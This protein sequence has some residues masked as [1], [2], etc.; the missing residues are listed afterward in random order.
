MSASLNLKLMIT[1][2]IIAFKMTFHHI[3][4]YLWLVFIEENNINNISAKLNEALKNIS[5][6][7]FNILQRAFIEKNICILFYLFS[8]STCPSLVFYLFTTINFK[9]LPIQQCDVSEITL[10]FSLN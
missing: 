4:H 8:F 5:G 3:M 1:K 2:Y 6:I 7:K 10:L 9:I